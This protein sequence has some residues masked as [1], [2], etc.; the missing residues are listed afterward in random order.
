M[1]TNNFLM[2]LLSNLFQNKT[3]IS[4]FEDMSAYGSLLMGL[5]GI[6]LVNN[7]NDLKKYKKNYIQFKPLNSRADI[8]T[9]NSWR[10]VLNKYYLNK[11]I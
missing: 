9:Y 10:D 11:N 3:N 1:T 6:K 7:L 2:Q 4:K 8:K 5:L